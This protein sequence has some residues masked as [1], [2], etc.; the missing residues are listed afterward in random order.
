MSV[1]VITIERSE[2]EKLIES[3][4]ARAVARTIAPP[5]KVMTKAETAAYIKKSQATLTRYMRKGMPHSTVGRPTFRQS[6]VDR[7]LAVN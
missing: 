2:L 4:V 1:E 6:E 5:D 7:W 3:T